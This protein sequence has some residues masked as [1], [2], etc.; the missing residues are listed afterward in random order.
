MQQSARI[1]EA[2]QTLKNPLMRAK[3]ILELNGVDPSQEGHT[4]SD[5]QFLMQ[6]MEL[7]ERLE[8]I[9]SSDDPFSQLALLSEEIDTILTKQEKEISTLLAEKSEQSLQQAQECVK[10]MQF[11]TKLQQQA[12]D[13]EEEFL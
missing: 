5:A 3:Y 2:F 8:S 7:R 4:T 10:R 6:Q 11:I 13:M 9:R 12:H 1:N